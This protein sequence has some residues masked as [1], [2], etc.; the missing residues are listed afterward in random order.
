MDNKSPFQRIKEVEAQVRVIL[1]RVDMDALPHAQRELILLI[2]RQASDAKL[3][4]RDYGMAE[5]KAD[6]TRFARE[7]QKRLELLQKKI[8]A[9]S[10][11]NLFSAID[12]AQL[13]ANLQ[14]VITDL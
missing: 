12:V 4:L 2:K 11:Y 13:S 6:Q 1:T 14:Q 3:D 5:T 8:I 9:A 10:E 7:A